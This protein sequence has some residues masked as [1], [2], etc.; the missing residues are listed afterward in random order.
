M[1]LLSRLGIDLLE[2]FLI[3]VTSL[4]LR[5]SGRQTLSSHGRLALA[6]GAEH[7]PLCVSISLGVSGPD[8]ST[9]LQ[10]SFQGSDGLMHVRSLEQGLTPGK[11]TSR[12]SN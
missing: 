4:A 3:G 7:V 2:K 9:C 6:G 8:H 11:L 1:I 10:G 12:V 5:F